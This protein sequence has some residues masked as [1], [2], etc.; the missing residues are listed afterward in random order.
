MTVRWTVGTKLAAG[1]GFAL[2]LLAIIGGVS[3]RSLVLVTET[4]A[5]VAHSHQVLENLE[6]LISLLKDAETGQRG[7]LLTRQER[8]LEPIRPPWEKSRNGYRNSAD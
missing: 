3:Y 6:G 7:F 1:F 5:S 4:A 2:L 8:Y